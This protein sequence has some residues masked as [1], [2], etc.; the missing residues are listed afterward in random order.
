MQT[1]SR[2]TRRQL[3]VASA[4]LL[5]LPTLRAQAPATAFPLYRG[6]QALQGLYGV[7]VPPLAQAFEKQAKAL[8]AAARQ[9]CAGPAALT[10]LIDAWRSSR[11]A[12]QALAHPTLGP[13]ITRRSQREIDFWPV[14]PALL[15]KALE[16]RPQTLADMARIGG[17]AKGFGAMELLLAGPAA[18]S[19]C[20]YLT[21]IAEGI[22]A[23]ARAL[24]EGFDE[25]AKKDWN[26]DED[27]A[28]TRFA[29]WINQWLG[30]LESLRWQQIEQP[31]QRAR[32]SGRGRA[33]TF[34]RRKPEDNRADWLA[35]WQSLQAQARL[36][37]EQR[38]EPPLPGQ[39]LVPIEALLLGKGH[40]ALAARWGQAVDAVS[41]G[42]AALPA[43]PG[44]RELMALST[45]MKAVSSLYQGEVAVA[46]D[47]PLGF[48][49]ADGD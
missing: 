20:P 35:Q 33:P 24:R 23:E 45:R 17:P 46:L 7:H 28:R 41:A 4:G 29:E 49:S 11:L 19:H 31:L 40:I 37:P 10:V 22:E 5:A 27:A 18:A 38:S 12:W 44:E 6:E 15:N 3:V 36:T 34:A 1:P 32:T 9:H 16:R 47:V 13:L 42:M 39:S 25:L 21:L 2:L 43:R 26:A 48:S 8:T 30:G 14:R